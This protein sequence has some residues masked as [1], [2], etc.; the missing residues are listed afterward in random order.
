MTT[1]LYSRISTSD[2]NLGM[3]REDLQAMCA[4]RR[5]DNL[6]EYEDT[7]SGAKRERPALDRLIADIK[8][9][10]VNRVVVWRYDRM[11]RGALHFLELLELFRVYNVQFVSIKE[12]LDT[13]TA[14]GR[15]FMTMI[16]A[17][18]ELER[19]TIRTRVKA[20]IAH[21]QAHGTRTGNRIGRPRLIFD[22]KLAEEM[23]RNGSSL[24]AISKSLGV[25]QSIVWRE[26]KKVS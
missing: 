3:Q 17:M 19:D 15:F 8:V 9:G 2:Q 25:S 10:R 6:K 18:S 11:A 13:E 26:L 14:M 21:A 23:Q 20:G 1:A 12:S 22:R 7:I 16:G 24:R 5:W 4:A